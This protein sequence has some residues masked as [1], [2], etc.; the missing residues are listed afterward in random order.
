MPTEHELGRLAALVAAAGITLVILLAAP[1]SIPDPWDKAAHFTAFS[2]LTFCLWQATGGSMPVLVVAGVIL[3]GALDECRQA[4]LPDR[5]SDARD[6]LA[7]LC[8]ALATG[9]LLFMQRK[10]KCAESSPR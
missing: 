6:F 1:V 10:P 8:A 7:D 5:V 9:A 3:L 4:Y 2:A